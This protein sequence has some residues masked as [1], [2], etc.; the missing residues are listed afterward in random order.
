MN[1]RSILSAIAFSFAA[2]T[3][4]A[5]GDD[6]ESPDNVAQATD[7]TNGKTISELALSGDDRTTLEEGQTTQLT[8]TLRYAD[9][10]TRD[11]TNEAQWNTSDP[12]NATVARGL[13]TA[14]DEGPVEISVTYNGITQRDSI[15]ITNP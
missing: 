13:V 14:I 10:T 1:M 2:A 12:S 9:G 5:C 7:P 11:V 15:V 8:A 6:A 4:V 3:V